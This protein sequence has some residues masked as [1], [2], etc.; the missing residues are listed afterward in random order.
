MCRFIEQT[1]E[2]II[3]LFM[4]FL[5]PPP[6]SGSS[7][8]WLFI[9]YCYVPSLPLSM[10]DLWLGGSLSSSKNL[11]RLSKES[12]YLL[13]LLLEGRKILFLQYF[14]SGFRNTLLFSSYIFSFFW[15]WSLQLLVSLC[16]VCN[17]CKQSVTE[18]HD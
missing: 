12:S 14:E 10:Y 8:T 4:L 15:Y 2:R 18:P 16:L 9:F 3:F 7:S 13:S 1:E 17:T 6:G 5:K 11:F